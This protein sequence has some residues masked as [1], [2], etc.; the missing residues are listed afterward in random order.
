MSLC[1]LLFCLVSFM[2][3]LKGDVWC[4]F[5]VGGWV[6]FDIGEEL[7]R[8]DHW[9]RFRRA[10]VTN[11]KHILQNLQKKNVW[12]CP[13]KKRSKI[14]YKKCG[15][16]N[17]CC[18]FIS[19]SFWV[20]FLGS[21]PVFRFLTHY[22]A[23]AFSVWAADWWQTCVLWDW[24]CHFLLFIHVCARQ[25]FL[26]LRHAHFEHSILEGQLVYCYLSE[27]GAHAKRGWDRMIFVLEMKN[28]E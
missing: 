8:S 19:L 10:S 9:P 11:S 6:L 20:V 13:L 23:S 5:Q 26:R 22:I 15:G 25:G 14:Q 21:W 3:N 1:K 27:H 24:L 4:G 18:F 7:G 12:H 2:F 17:W 28:A 16:K